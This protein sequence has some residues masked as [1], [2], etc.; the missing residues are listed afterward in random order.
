MPTIINVIN[1]TVLILGVAACLPRAAAELI[2]ACIP[3]ITAIAELRARFD[4]QV[5]R[6]GKHPA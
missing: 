5:S 3:V 6:L 1:E 2:Y 4:S